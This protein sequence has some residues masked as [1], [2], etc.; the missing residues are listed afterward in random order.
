MNLIAK[1]SLMSCFSVLLCAASFSAYATAVKDASDSMFVP[2]GK[3]FGVKSNLAPPI[4]NNPSIPQNGIFY[5][6]G[7]VMGTTSTAIPNIYYIWYGNWSGNSAISILVNFARGIGSTSY[8]NINTTYTD[9]NGIPVI[10]AAN[11]KAGITDRYSHGTALNDNDIFSI[12]DRILTLKKLP[13]DPN[14][15]YFVLTSADVNETGG[16]CSQY[17][18]WHTSGTS[19]NTN[20]KYAFIGNGARCPNSC[21]AQQQS[22]PNNNVGADGMASVIAH[23]LEESVTDPHGNA[24]YDNSGNENADKCAWHFGTTHR[25]PN[26][27]LYN[28]AVGA[29]QYMIQMNWLNANGGLCVNSH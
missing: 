13:L 28:M 17:C 18:G 20:I 4:V 26:G 27:S 21:T 25:A 11:F 9:G 8:Y 12:V 23:E 14:G 2:T 10:R 29:K 5:H 16:F 15:I 3:G 7:P 1:S 6:G 24:W 19:N 22:S